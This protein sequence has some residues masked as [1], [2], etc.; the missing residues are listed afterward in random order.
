MKHLPG[1]IRAAQAITGGVYGSE[2][3]YATAYG[4]KTVAGIADLIQNEMHAAQLVA[5]CRR[6]MGYAPNE[7]EARILSGAIQAVCE[8]S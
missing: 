8:E 3:R 7:V 5:A 1:E 2:A 4:Q 6:E